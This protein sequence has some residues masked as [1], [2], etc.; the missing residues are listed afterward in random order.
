MLKKITIKLESE[1]YRFFLSFCL[2]E[3]YDSSDKLI[4]AVE[5][6]NNFFDFKVTEIYFIQA[7][8]RPF[9]YYKLT[10][11]KNLPHDNENSMLG[12]QY[13]VNKDICDNLNV[14]RASENTSKNEAE[15]LKI[16]SKYFL[17]GNQGKE[18]TRI[19]LYKSW[20]GMPKY[21]VDYKKNKKIG[22]Q[23]AVPHS[24]SCGSPIEQIL[25]N[26]LTAS[27]INFITQQ[28]IYYN[29]QLLTILD[30][31]LD[32]Q[33][34]AIYC[35][36]FEFHYNKDSVIKDRTQDR[37]L[38]LLGYKVLRYTGSEIHADVNK[39]VKEIQ[40]FLK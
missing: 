19:H 20:T 11:R 38:Q 6:L 16:L 40:L 7:D 5:E 28:R 27:G 37:I 36:G 24:N 25:S 18:I 13:T 30:F 15:L 26:A 34:I 29:E 8:G 35:D 22:S 23:F 4:S 32:S 9:H 14:I 21:F 10:D 33:K 39:C 1:N 17:S 3:E 31:Y 12:Y 2:K